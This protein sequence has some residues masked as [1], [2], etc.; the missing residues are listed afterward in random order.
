[1]LS[2]PQNEK[3]IEALVSLVRKN[4]PEL[5]CQRNQFLVKLRR[6]AAVARDV[7]RRI[8]NAAGKA[9]QEHLVTFI[10]R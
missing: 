3:L 8:V 9:I 1:M 4:R 5:D 7:R 6:I 10:D 2:T